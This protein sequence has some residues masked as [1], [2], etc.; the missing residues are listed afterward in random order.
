MLRAYRSV[1]KGEASPVS[2]AATDLKGL[3]RAPLLLLVAALLVVGFFPN[4]LLNALKPVVEA[5]TPR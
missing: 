5:L 1:F 3:A 2:A 4:T